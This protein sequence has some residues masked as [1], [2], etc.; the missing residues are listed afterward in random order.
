MTQATKSTKKTNKSASSPAG[1]QTEEK[2]VALTLKIDGPTYLRL[3]MLRARERR[4]HQDI[5]VAALE[6]YLRQQGV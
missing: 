5:L 6:A 3:T 2:P 1:K 4:T